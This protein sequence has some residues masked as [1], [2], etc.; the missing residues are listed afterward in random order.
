[1]DIFIDT[2]SILFSFGNKK[3]LFDNLLENF[4]GSRLIISQGVM[5]ELEKLAATRKRISSY[6]K[7]AIKEISNNKSIIVE[8]NKQVPDLWL[9]GKAKKSTYI[10]TND[11]A[12]KQK[13][14]RKGARVVSVSKDGKLR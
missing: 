2:S 3:D 7:I 8:K 5:G 1:M 13:L 9:L 6:A 12:L 10:C 14:K 11:I 4:P